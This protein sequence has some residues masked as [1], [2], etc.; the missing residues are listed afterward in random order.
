MSDPIDEYCDVLRDEFR[1]LP[2]EHELVAELEDHLRERAEALACGATQS[3]EAE[4][5]AVEL[6]GS[7]ELV[8]RRVR[9][10]LGLRRRHEPVTVA[11]WAF[12]II[13]LLLL[14]VAL[15][16]ATETW[17]YWLPCD[18][19]TR[20]AHW[21]PCAHAMEG[22]GGPNPIAAGLRLSAVLLSTLAWLIF[23]AGQ[24]WHTATRRLSRVVIALSLAMAL[25]TLLTQ[26]ATLGTGWFWAP[27]VALGV[28]VIV[29]LTLRWVGLD[30][31]HP[32]QG[33]S[34]ES[35]PRPQ[36]PRT[37]YLVRTA[38]LLFAATGLTRWSPVIVDYFIMAPV[39]ELNFDTPP[40]TG[41]VTA[42]LIGLSA[43]TSMLLGVV[44][45]V[46]TRLKQR[47]TEQ[48]VTDHV[49]APHPSASITVVQAQR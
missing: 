11:R 44:A 8:A 4:R 12:P 49:G 14:T 31:L 32:R 41:Y 40:G 42:A 30:P 3:E 7:P 45:W 43:L 18:V 47:E 35:R 28:E 23:A 17:V 13:E 36:L 37:I 19:Q 2:G 39:S 26:S 34:H 6:F 22:D 15:I 9:S 24:P 48:R 16:A 46:V 33:A 20:A 38:I 5:R 27:V 21:D 10:T 29:W 1:E 25:E